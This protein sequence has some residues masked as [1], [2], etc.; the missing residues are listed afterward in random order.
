MP[1]RLRESG[2]YLLTGLS[3]IDFAL[4]RYLAEA[5]HARLIRSAT[6]RSLRT[7]EVQALEEAGAEVLLLKADFTEP[8]SGRRNHFAGAS[9]VRRNQRRSSFRIGHVGRHGS[10]RRRKR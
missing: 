5:A 8:R 3:D 6:M 10:T 1:P 4:T 9:A 7:S 2:V